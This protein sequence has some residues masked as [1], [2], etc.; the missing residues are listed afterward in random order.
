M[1]K[2]QVS[3][4]PCVERSWTPQSSPREGRGWTEDL[5]VQGRVTDGSGGGVV[6]KGSPST[7]RPQ[8]PAAVPHREEPTGQAR[9]MSPEGASARRCQEDNSRGKTEGLEHTRNTTPRE[10]TGTLLTTGQ[11][12]RRCLQCAKP[13]GMRIADLQIVSENQ[14]LKESSP[15]P[16]PQKRSKKDTTSIY[17]R[18]DQKD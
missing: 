17:R 13:W 3:A 1:R 14:V 15:T 12:G 7:L 9:S 11:S 8:A 10:T 16:T 5:K 2:G 18:G 6:A 4:A